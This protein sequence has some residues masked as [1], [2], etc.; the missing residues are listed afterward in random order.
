MLALD[1]AEHV[2]TARHQRWLGRGLDRLAPPHGVAAQIERHGV[3]DEATIDEDSGQAARVAGIEAQLDVG[4]QLGLDLEQ[5][6]LPAYGAV[7][8]HLSFRAVQEDHVEVHVARYGTNEAIFGEQVCPRLATGRGVLAVVIDGVE[9]RP[10]FRVEVDQRQRHGGKLVADLGAPR[11]VESFDRALG[12]G[13]AR[14]SV[15]KAYAELGAD[16]PQRVGDVCRAEIDVVRARQAM[17]HE[18]FAQA[19]LVVDMPSLG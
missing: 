15:P 8:S 19:M 17:A 10:V 6:A 12:L 9:P 5:A 16:D 14:C 4:P 7:L 1:V 18:G 13:V 2:D 11:A 3:A